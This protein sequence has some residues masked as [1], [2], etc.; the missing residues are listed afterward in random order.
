MMTTVRQVDAL[1]SVITDIIKRMEV[2]ELA[3]EGWDNIPARTLN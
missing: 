3:A 2:V 1:E